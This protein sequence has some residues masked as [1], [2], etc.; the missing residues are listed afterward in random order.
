M[1]RFCA[2]FSRAPGLAEAGASLA[3][4]RISRAGAVFGSSLGC[5]DAI[6]EHA[7]LV[8]AATGLG[9]LR[10]GVFATT[11]H[12]TVIAELSSAYGLAGP[13]EMLVTGPTAGLEALLV[14]A[15]ILEAGRAELVVAGAAEGVRPELEEAAGG[16]LTGGGAALVLRREDSGKTLG[17]FSGGALFLRDPRRGRRAAAAR[18][19]LSLA[20][21]GRLDALPPWRSRRHRPPLAARPP[22]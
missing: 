6:T 9:D 15:R 4:R 3:P 17:R 16:S 11:V 2:R 18:R 21:P 8:A 1:D 7:L 5:A 14:A 20:R 13:A 22:G 19:A 10:P 12:N